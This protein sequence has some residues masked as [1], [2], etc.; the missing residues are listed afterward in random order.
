[1]SLPLS[2][3]A[4]ALLAQGYYTP[5]EAQAVFGQAN[6]AYYRQDYAAAVEGYQKLVERGF[7]GA[8]LLYN[9]GTAHLARNDLG[10]AVLYLERARREGGDTE[11]IDAN[12]ALARSRQLDQVVGAQAEEP[13]LSRLTAA[14]NERA[15]SWFFLGAWIVLFGALLLF[16]FQTPGRRGW[17]VVAIL[18]ALA[19]AVPAGGVLAAHV[20]AS[21]SVQEGV[22]VAETARARELPKDNASV[23]FEIHSGLKVRLFETSGNYVRIRLPNGLEGWTQADAVAR[24]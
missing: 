6:E 20:Y 12:L 2:L 8:D 1:M 9:L 4:A 13:F 15:A 22:I 11:D 7:G 10:R 19:L 5:D 21:S 24:L 14:T 3:L 17:T 18:A 23:S 16:R